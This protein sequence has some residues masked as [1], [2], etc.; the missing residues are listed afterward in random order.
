MEG[1]GIAMMDASIYSIHSRYR[2]I[3]AHVMTFNVLKI[4][5][6]SKYYG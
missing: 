6:P 4:I 2:A 1:K 5:A 3:V